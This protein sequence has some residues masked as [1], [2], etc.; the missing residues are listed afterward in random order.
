[1]AS[2]VYL[3]SPA[4][5]LARFAIKRAASGQQSSRMCFIFSSDGTRVREHHPHGKF[6]QK[7][8]NTLYNEPG[9]F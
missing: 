5:S 6:T 2:V 1:M 8:D 4:N 3:L 9:R 7:R